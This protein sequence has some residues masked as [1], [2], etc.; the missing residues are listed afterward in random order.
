LF[1][2]SLLEQAPCFATHNHF[3]AM[4][5]QWHHVLR[6]PNLQDM[7]RVKFT[8]QLVRA[9]ITT[10]WVYKY[11]R[12]ATKGECF[13]DIQPEMSTFGEPSSRAEDW[14]PSVLSSLL[15]LCDNPPRKIL[16]YRLKP[17]HFGHY[18]IVKYRPIVSCR[19]NTP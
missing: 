7:R 9:N 10:S 19:V 4:N 5:P 13:D 18:A 12:I 14:S 15:S 16:Y 2:M 17:I 6:R 3:F 11:T 1:R 8:K